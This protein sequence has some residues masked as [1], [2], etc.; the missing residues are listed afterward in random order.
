[1][2]RRMAKQG[3][4]SVVQRNLT[5]FCNSILF[6][7]TAAR[8]MVSFSTVRRTSSSPTFKKAG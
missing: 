8:C 6:S 2:V 4:V 5:R 7:N 1:M 3:L